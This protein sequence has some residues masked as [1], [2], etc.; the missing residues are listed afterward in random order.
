[1]VQ[2]ALRHGAV[3]DVRGTL[4]QTAL[5]GILN[6]ED[7]RAVVVPGDEPGIQGSAEIAHVHIAS[8]RG[9]EPGPNPTLGDTGFHLLNKCVIN[10]HESTSMHNL[11]D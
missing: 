10:R 2:A 3:D 6:A 5:V 9:S 11:T 1:M 7:E 4:H 8:G